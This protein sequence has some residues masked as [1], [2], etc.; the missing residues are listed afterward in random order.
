MTGAPKRGASSWGE[1]SGLIDAHMHMMA[2]E[3]LGGR[4]H[5]GRPW[6]PYGVAYA[7]VDCPDHEPRGAG[8]VVENTI[9]YGNP[10]G[11]HDT[12]GWPTFKDWPNH[13]SLTHEQSYYKWLERSWRAGQ[14]VFVN[15]LVDN[16]VLCEVYPLQEELLQRDGR[17][18]AP[19]QAH[20]R[21]AGLHRRPER[22]AGQG[23]VP[24]RHDARTRRAA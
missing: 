23:L 4:A 2:F 3:F 11:F 15:L 14:R 24:D 1:V 20:P 19:E 9:S 12:T 21:A 6:H 8:A 10:V 17:R 16:A 5:C 22:R 13:A 7:M 18:A